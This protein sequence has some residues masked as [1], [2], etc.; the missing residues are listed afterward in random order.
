MTQPQTVEEIWLPAT[1]ELADNLTRIWRIE[2]KAPA[3]STSQLAD[4]EFCMGGYCFFEEQNVSMDMIFRNGTLR[5]LRLFDGDQD[6][7]KCHFYVGAS[8]K[9][10]FFCKSDAQ[11]RSLEVETRFKQKWLPMFRR[12]CYLSGV[13]IECTAH[14]QLEWTLWLR[15]QEAVN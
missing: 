3:L 8:G 14:E 13:P 1:G 2:G 5:Y 11:G 7:G 10:E 15:D 6:K 4:G 12:N 9:I